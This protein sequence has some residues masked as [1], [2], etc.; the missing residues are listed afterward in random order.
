MGPIMTT[1]S[2]LKYPGGKYYD[3]PWIVSHFPPHIHY[4]EPFA[5]SAAVLFAS[6]Q[7]ERSEVLN[8]LDHKLA[9]FWAVLADPNLSPQFI[10]AVNLLPVSR[11]LWEA[12]DAWVDGDPVG[13]AV[14]YFVRVRQSFCGTQKQ[15]SPL[16]KTRT[17]RGINEQASAWLSA[18]DM[19]P[20]IAERLRT[21]VVEC[22]P[23]VDVIK[24]EDR[25]GT[26]FYLD[27]EYFPGTHHPGLYSCTMSVEDHK[28]LV[29]LLR[30]VRGKVV[31]SGYDN[32]L[33]ADYLRGWRRVE[34]DRANAMQSAS[35]KGSETEMLWM[36]F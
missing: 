29:T 33:Y 8:D 27:P 23:A 9:N 14:R 16:T 34:R 4:V 3:A 32:P 13:N 24:S 19:L 5:G 20:A 12:A 17:R 25:P 35:Y 22:R 21:V 2:P 6:T 30:D 28:A 15:F 10:Q 1:R 11:A 26:L 31:L 7:D 36:N 18:V